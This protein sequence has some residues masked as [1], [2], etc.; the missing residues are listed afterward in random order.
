MKYRD[1]DHVTT[2]CYVINK[3][4]CDHCY[5]VGYDGRI[6]KCSFCGKE[7]EIRFFEL[8]GFHDKEAYL[9][10]QKANF[11]DKNPFAKNTN[12]W[13]NWNNGKNTNNN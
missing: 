12:S 3:K 11:K 9:L 5:P 4:E 10:G 8:D 2:G 7:K 1:E 6:N 13:F